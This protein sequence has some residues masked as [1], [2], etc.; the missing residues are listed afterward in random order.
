MSCSDCNICL[1]TASDPIRTSCGHLYCWPCLNQWIQSTIVQSKERHTC[2]VCRR[3]L[4]EMDLTQIYSRSGN[5]K[6]AYEELGL[7]VQ[8]RSDE[9]FEVE[10]GENPRWGPA[11]RLHEDTQEENIESDDIPVTSEVI[12]AMSVVLE[13]VAGRVENRRGGANMQGECEDSVLINI[14]NVQGEDRDFIINLKDFIRWMRR[15]ED[16]DSAQI[17][18]VDLLRWTSEV[19]ENSVVR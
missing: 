15:G 14:M 11:G 7:A 10:M 6:R 18:L 2:P 1:E 17:N 3:D 9:S 5:S 12:Q 16:R 4:T 8:P 13:Y 19:L